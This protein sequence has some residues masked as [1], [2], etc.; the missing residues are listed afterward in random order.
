VIVRSEPSAPSAARLFDLS[1]RVALVT[2]SS[3]G[4]GRAIALGL[5]D[6]GSAVAIHCAS[7]VQE[8]QS[9][10][11]TI[12][13]AG[14]RATA[15]AADLSSAQACRELVA[16]TTARLGHIDILV[17]NASAEIRRDWRDV[18]DDDFDIQ[19][20]VNFRAPLLLM[21]SVVPGMADRGWGR[22]VSIGSIQ[23]VK[24]NPRLLVYAALKCAQ[25]NVIVNLARQ[26]AARG[27]TLNNLA[28]GAIGTERNAAVLQDAAYR[29]RVEAQIPARRLGV[30]DD[31][32]GACLLLCTEAGSYITGTTLFVDGGWHRS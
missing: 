19:V 20:A 3:R 16:E 28:P 8:A 2:G 14:R 12:E 31:C 7:R 10:A 32:V 5:A 18:S 29:S 24:P 22:V 26:Y 9:V 13:A 30:P 27:V 6:C 4:I 15:I 11:G 21:Q 17:L 25:A 1:G 23:E